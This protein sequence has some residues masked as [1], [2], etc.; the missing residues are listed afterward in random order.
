MLR[1]PTPRGATSRAL[2]DALAR[3]PHAPV[4]VPVGAPEDPLADDDLQ[5]ALY[6]CYELH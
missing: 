4:G 2:L 5:L 3:P 6:C 1:L